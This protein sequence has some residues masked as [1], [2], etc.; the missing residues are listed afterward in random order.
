MLLS[1]ASTSTDIST[2][3]WVSSHGKSLC[4]FLKVK[5]SRSTDAKLI[6]RNISKN[7]AMVKSEFQTTCADRNRLASAQ[8]KLQVARR[9][10]VA[11]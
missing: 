8:A 2:K 1:P 5:T 10:N 3:Q 4:G 11:D 7:V 6:K 9:S